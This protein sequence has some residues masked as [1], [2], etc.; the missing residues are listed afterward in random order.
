MSAL[1][2]ASEDIQRQ[3]YI[4]ILVFTAQTMKR[5]AVQKE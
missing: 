2:W 1:A 4:Q 3:F 5:N